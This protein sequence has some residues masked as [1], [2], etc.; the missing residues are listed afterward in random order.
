MAH[1]Y[2]DLKE[3]A[4]ASLL[5]CVGAN[6]QGSTASIAAR[7]TPH[8]LGKGLGGGVPSSLRMISA[9][10]C[11]LRLLS[12]RQG[13]MR[14]CRERGYVRWDVSD[15][16]LRALCQYA[17][18]SVGRRWARGRSTSHAEAHAHAHAH[19]RTMSP[20]PQ[21]EYSSC[22]HNLELRRTSKSSFVSRCHRGIRTMACGRRQQQWCHV[23]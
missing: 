23:A 4:H 10:T 20:T 15:A 22:A 13:S 2:T 18:W 21:R 19:V 3:E 11:A 17:K 1:S 8:H 12:A 6:A 5:A 7:I 14:T 16:A 9:T